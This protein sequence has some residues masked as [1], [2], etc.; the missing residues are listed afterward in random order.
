M[1]SITCRETI[2]MCGL[3]NEQCLYLTEN[4]K[5]A[6]AGKPTVIS[7]ACICW[8]VCQR[9]HSF[10]QKKYAEPGK[11]ATITGKVDD[12]N[13]TGDGGTATVTNEEGKILLQISGGV[14]IIKK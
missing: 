2:W 6:C 4:N 5:P 3:N 9:L 13:K 10:V 14:L 8:D 1:S 11:P 7:D 12:G